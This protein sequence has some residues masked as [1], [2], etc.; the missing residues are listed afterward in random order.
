MQRVR[1]IFVVAVVSLVALSAAAQLGQSFSNL[2]PEAQIS[3]SRTLS[4]RV[5]DVTLPQLAKLTASDGLSLDQLGFS[6]AIDG[7]TVVVGL[8]GSHRAV[9]VFVKPPSGWADM[10]E[11]AELTPSDAASG[12]GYT[13]GVS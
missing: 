8:F 13:V 2:P 3:I 12:F 6:A 7:D 9:W 1:A 5:P 11:T 10:T 4:E